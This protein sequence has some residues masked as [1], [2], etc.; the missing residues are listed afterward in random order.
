[1]KKNKTGKNII[2]I[3]LVALI[4]GVVIGMFITN[5]TTGNAS[6]IISLG[7]RDNAGC[8]SGGAGTA[9]DPIVI[10]T[11]EDLDHI[12]NN[13]E[14]YYVLGQDIDLG[15]YP[16]NND[17]GWEP[18]GGIEF[19]TR[20]KGSLDGAGHKILNLYINKRNNDYVGLFGW[21]DSSTDPNRGII[22]N[23]GL[24]NINVIGHDNV[25]GL[26]G[27]GNIIRNCYS[28]GSVS[29]N[30]YV[31]GLIGTSSNGLK[32]NHSSC[33]VN[34]NENVGG[35]CG[36]AVNAGLQDCSATGDVSGEQY[37]GGLVGYVSNA[38]V[39]GNYATGNVSGTSNNVGGLF[40][41]VGYTPI[42]NCYAT[43]EVSGVVTAFGFGVGGLIGRVTYNSPITNCY[44]V[45]HVSGTGNSYYIGGLIGSCGTAVV[46]N[47]YWNVQTS[48]RS[49]SCG[50]TGKI[51]SDMKTKRTFNNWN[52][53]NTWNIY[54]NIDNLD[55]EINNT[56]LN[57]NDGYPYLRNNVP[58]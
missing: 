45:G 52:F 29:G 35:L 9:H 17:S 22:K 24:E 50:G 42:T 38:I 16:Y 15:V 7:A 3:T 40:G 31:G 19:N 56:N 4:V 20:F 32:N 41:F 26:A 34:G 47:S 48:G 55:S 13:L 53:T 5:A 46:T 49:N 39:S 54:K 51:T 37:V 30:N 27:V 18:I 58:E 57:L 2:I 12:R 6:E 1:M 21:Q 33:S 8:I 28:T 23:L 11:P 36:S 44:S 25:G 10:C 14:A 43:G